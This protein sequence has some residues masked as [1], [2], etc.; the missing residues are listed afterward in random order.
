M[1]NLVGI[2]IFFMIFVSATMAQDCSD[3]AYPPRPDPPCKETCI[4]K[5]LA[6]VTITEFRFFFQVNADTAKKLVELNS[7][8]VR[9]GR[10]PSLEVYK[11]SNLFSNAEISIF[12]IRLKALAEHQIR[13]LLAPEDTKKHT[14]DDLNI[15]FE[16][17]DKRKLKLEKSI[18]AVQQTFKKRNPSKKVAS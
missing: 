10:V 18:F 6:K 3:C 12:E 5:A 13:Y 14:R 17:T 2:F 8:L 4:N 1:R 7:R 16:N 11:K 15:Y 9:G